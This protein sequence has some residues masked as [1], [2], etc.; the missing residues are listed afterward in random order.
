MH[1][2]EAERGGQVPQGPGG[3]KDLDG[4]TPGAGPVARPHEEQVV[5]RLHSEDVPHKLRISY[6]SGELM[7]LMEHLPGR[8]AIPARGDQ[9]RHVR[10]QAGT[11]RA[12]PT[13]ERGK[14]PP[15]HL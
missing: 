11:I 5:D 14:P 8:L 1:A 7:C 9:D 13:C 12:Y 15:G 2:E 10:E 4:T 6:S 3:P